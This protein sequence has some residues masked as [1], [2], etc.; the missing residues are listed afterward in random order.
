MEKLTRI[1]CNNEWLNQGWQ[2]T[3][4]SGRGMILLSEEVPPWLK[5]TSQGNF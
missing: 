5:Q 1:I 4:E 3:F 2:T